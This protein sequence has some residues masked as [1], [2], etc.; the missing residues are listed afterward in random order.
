[1]RVKSTEV[2]LDEKDCGAHFQQTFLGQPVCTTAKPSP[3]KESWLSCDQMAGEK[4]L[5]LRLLR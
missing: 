2:L 4:R 5:P 3:L 1:M